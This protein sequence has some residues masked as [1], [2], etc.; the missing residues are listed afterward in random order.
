MAS[1]LP[2]PPA[3]RGVFARLTVV[4]ACALLCAPASGAVAFILP[5]QVNHSGVGRRNSM[6]SGPPAASGVRALLPPVRLSAAYPFVA[7]AVESQAASLGGGGGGDGR[8]LAPT[9]TKEIGRQE[10]E[11]TCN[12]RGTRTITIRKECD[13]NS[14]VEETT[15]KKIE[16]NQVVDTTT[17]N[18]MV[19]WG[20]RHIFNQ[21]SSST[22]C[23]STPDTVFHPGSFGGGGGG[24]E[25][26]GNQD[27]DGGQR[28]HHRTVGII[29]VVLII[30]GVLVG[31]LAFAKCVTDSGGSARTY[32][33]PGPPP[34]FATGGY[35]FRSPA[36]AHAQAAAAN[37]FHMGTGPGAGTIPSI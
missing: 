25:G 34:G 5:D 6:S 29:A 13:D 23:Q 20:E 22:G 24:G 7:P 2:C 26:G 9:C 32:R 33:Q 8:R 35:G 14:V 12:R 18:K 4:C 21:E 1:A 30:I 15:V 36:G 31:G 27:D 16:N 28:R 19:P 10:S 37:R 17:T 3:S 11:D